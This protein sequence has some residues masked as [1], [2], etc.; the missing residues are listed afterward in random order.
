MTNINIKIKNLLN[1]LNANILDLGKIK[2]QM[3]LISQY[4]E[5]ENYDYL[6][7]LLYPEKYTN[8]RFPSQ[9]AVPS[10]TF[11]LKNSLTISTN[12]VGC[13]LIK[14]NPFFLAQENAVGTSFIHHYSYSPPS[15]ISLR[16]YVTRFLSAMNYIDLSSFDG[17]NFRRYM[18]WAPLNS[19]QIVANDLYDQYRL[20]SGSISIRYIGGLDDACG[21]LG[22][23]ILFRKDKELSCEMYF[24]TATN[25]DPEY[26]YQPVSTAYQSFY[27]VKQEEC[28]FKY[29]RDASY[30]KEVSCLDGI[31]ML[32]FPL[33]N[34]FSEFKKV[35]N[36]D[37]LFSK[38]PVEM[39][40]GM[41]TELSVF[42]TENTYKTGFNWYLY[43]KDL[44]KNK[45]CLKLDLIL[46]YE[47]LLNSRFMNFVPISMRPFSLPNKEMEIIR[48]KMKNW[49]IQKLNNYS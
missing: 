17:V 6:N 19:N 29:L 38:V 31:R 42:S 9:V 44:P 33:D 36:R 10:A 8:V 43:G 45:N 18:Q 47:C 14:C 11:Q 13:F 1:L 22:G 7:C 2:Y 20:V 3:D 5:S 4:K 30:N 40:G 25:S 48:Y 23:S 12:D 16:H 34:S 27:G 24:N 28:L 41:P 15:F 49:S 32:Y 39:G 35:I 26:N 21:F 37:S 46:N